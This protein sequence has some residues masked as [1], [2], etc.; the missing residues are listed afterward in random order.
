[1]AKYAPHKEN[2]IAFIEYLISKGVQ[3]KFAA[4]NYEYPVNSEAKV[5][6]LLTSWGTFKEDS[7][8]L[9]KLGTLNKKAVITFDEVGW[10]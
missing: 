10:Q 5:A 8:S 4:A 1:M 6:E 9:S 7:L 3:E 2:A